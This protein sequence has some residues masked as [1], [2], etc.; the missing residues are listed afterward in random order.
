MMRRVLFLTLA[1]CVACYNRREV[2]RRDWGAIPENHTIT[3]GMLDGTQRE[4][5]RFVFTNAGLSGWRRAKNQVDTLL[6]VDSVLVPLDSIAVV[7]VSELDK[8]A[9]LVLAAAAVTG[10]FVLIGQAESDVRPAPVPRPPSSSCPFIYSFDGKNWVFDSE[11]YAGAVARALERMDTDNLEHLRAVDGRYRLRMK[12][13]RRETDYTDELALVVVDHPEGTRAISDVAGTVHVVGQGTRPRE[14]RK[15]G[16]DTIPSRAGWELSFP[17]P[18]GDTAALVL[19]VRNTFVG[20]F[21]L[22]HTLGLLGSSV[23][24]WYATLRG[25]P[26]ARAVVRAW[27]EREGYLDVQAAT[28]GGTWKSVARLPDVGGAISK[29]EVVVIDLRG[30]TGD[31]VRVRLESSPELWVLESADLAPYRGRATPDRLHSLQPLRATDERGTDVAPLLARRDGRYLVTTRGS[32]V[33]FEYDVPPAA[34]SGMTRSVLVR[35]V[36]HYYV[37]TDDRAPPRLDVVER[38]M[39]DRA[40]AQQYFSD[41]WVAAGNEPLVKPR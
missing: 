35:T 10:A 27:M 29:L 18:A 9:T 12:N 33:T 8:S 13:E 38:L 3:V 20:S 28:D 31:T 1:G 39:R 34:Q 21:A 22:Y 36:G 6:R 25:Q 15:F 40:F 2:P 4:F 5:H 23:Y 41:A 14:M 16:G 30:M 11:T 17:R 37:E 7:R 32:D 26:M 19:R 24:N